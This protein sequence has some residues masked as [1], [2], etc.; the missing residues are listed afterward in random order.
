MDLSF[1]PNRTEKRP[2]CAPVQIEPIFRTQS[3]ISLGNQV[4]AE[5]LRRARRGGGLTPG[6]GPGGLWSREKCVRERMPGGSGGGSR[7]SRS[8]SKASVQYNSGRFLGD[9]NP[10]ALAA[11]LL[12]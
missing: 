3:I 4:L 2:S 12:G 10:R 8:G 1:A 7:S 9:H 11:S 5:Q 6:G